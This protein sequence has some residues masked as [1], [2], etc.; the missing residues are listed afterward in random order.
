[1]CD[2]FSGPYNGNVK[3]EGKR[4]V[5]CTYMWLTSDDVISLALLTDI[6]YARASPAGSRSGS[7]SSRLSYATYSPHHPPQH[8]HSPAGGTLGRTRRRSGIPRST[9]TSREPS[10]TRYGGAHYGAYSHT[11]SGMTTPKNR[12]RSISG[13][14]ERGGAF[15][16]IIRV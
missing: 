14:R 2:K 7:P 15:I 13:E 1:M 11:S 8:Q 6:V 10:P 5:S 16:S 4:V 3:F 9:G 12:T